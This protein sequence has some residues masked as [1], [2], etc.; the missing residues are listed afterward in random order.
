MPSSSSVPETAVIL[1][2][3]VAHGG[4][5]IAVDI[6]E[7]ALAID[8]CVALREILRQARQRIIDRLVAM[9]VI[10]THHLADD[11]GAFAEGGVLGAG[12]SRSSR[13]RCVD[14]PASGHREHPAKRDA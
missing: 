4:G 3:S 13:K 7:I 10:V 8:Q 2:F 14:E 6:A 5:A 9:R 11:L 12:P 1:G